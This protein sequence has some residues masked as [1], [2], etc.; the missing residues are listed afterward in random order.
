[1][2]RDVPRLRNFELAKVLRQAFVKG[3][4]REGFRICQ[5]SIQG[6][7][8]HTICE[9]GDRERLAR[10]VQ[11]WCVRIARGINGV[12]DREGSLFDDRYHVEVIKSP[13]QMRNALCYVLQNARRHGERLDGKYHGMDPFSSAWWFDGWAHERWRFGLVPADGP[14]VAPATSWLLT[15][16]WRRRGLILSSPPLL[17]RAEPRCRAPRSGP[18]PS[19]SANRR[20]APHAER[21]RLRAPPPRALRRPARRR[22]GSA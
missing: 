15:T 14:P 11:G 22:R 8:I 7:H 6:N 20:A 2:R 1:M 16:G 5:F 4:R 13:R 17:L 21:Y 18:R 9:A 3:C 10:G 19:R 12:V